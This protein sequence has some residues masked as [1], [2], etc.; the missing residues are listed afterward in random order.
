MSCAEVRRSL[1][2][3]GLL[4]LQDKELPSVATIFGGGPMSK[5]WW[6]HPRAQEMFRCL[7]SIEDDVLATRLINGKVTFVHRRLWPA[8]AA[9]GVAIENNVHTESGRHEKRIEPG[10]SWMKRLEVKP[11]PSK[12]AGQSALE[13]AAA[14]FGAPLSSLP[15]R[16]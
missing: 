13:E 12:E 4:L 8:L 2:R 1:E 16:R 3:F 15:W 10:K 7:A 14:T 11:L 9:S 6:S 5:S